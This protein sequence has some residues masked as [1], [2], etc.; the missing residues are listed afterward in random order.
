LRIEE[1]KNY[2]YRPLD[3]CDTQNFNLTSNKVFGATQMQTQND[4][5]VLMQSQ[6]KL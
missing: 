4:M 1:G 5:Q 6:M 2:S 3:Q